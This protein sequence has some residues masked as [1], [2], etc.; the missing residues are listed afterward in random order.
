M[1]KNTFRGLITMFIILI[2]TLIMKD[3]GKIHT[4]FSDIPENMNEKSRQ[5]IVELEKSISTIVLPDDKYYEK[6]IL[7]NKDVPLN[8][9]FKPKNIKVADVLSNKNI[10]LE[11]DCAYSVKNM[12]DKA[13]EDG[14]ELML[15]SGYRTYDYQNNIFNIQVKKYGEIEANKLVARPGESEHQS[16]LSVDITSKSVGYLLEESFDNTDEYKWLM[17]NAYKFGFILRYPKDK[18]D[19]TKYSYEPW[20]FRYIGD[21]DVAK[22]ITSEGITLEEYLDIVKDD[23]ISSIPK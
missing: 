23:N 11:E 2:I 22:Y 20:H 13:L 14:I 6:F 10:L 1:Y 4:V 8:S 17:Q 21:D 7:V 15:V 12:F 5:N 9:T 18:E 19:I 3:M 16:G